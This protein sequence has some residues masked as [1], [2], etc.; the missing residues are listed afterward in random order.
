MVRYTIMMCVLAVPPRTRN[1][2]VGEVCAV[3]VL[4]CIIAMYRKT[5][6][7]LSSNKDPLPRTVLRMYSI[8]PRKQHTQYIHTSPSIQQQQ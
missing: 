5:R 6:N 2:S 3:L 7:D 4:V 8:E 1:Q